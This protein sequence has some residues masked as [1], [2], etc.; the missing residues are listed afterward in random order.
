MVFLNQIE[1]PVNVKVDRFEGIF[2]NRSPNGPSFSGKG[3]ALSYH[4]EED[5]ELA[6]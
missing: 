1:L 6:G 3:S 4:F 2:V 5:G